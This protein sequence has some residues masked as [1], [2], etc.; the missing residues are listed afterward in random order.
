MAL[1]VLLADESSTIKKVMQLSLQDFGV[2]VKS[3]PL[4]VDVL[5][6]AQSFKPDLIFIDIL[7]QKKNGYEVCTDLKKDPMLSKVPVI[8]MWSGFMDLDEEKVKTAKADGRLEKP[9]DNQTL[10]SLVEKFVIKTQEH[11]LKGFLKFPD[12]PEFVEAK[13]TTPPTTPLPNLKPAARPVIPT[14]KPLEDFPPL[15]DAEF[16]QFKQV[17]LGKKGAEKS[18]SLDSFKLNLNDLNLEAPQNTSAPWQSSPMG[19]ERI[20]DSDFMVI[21]PG[22]NLEDLAKEAPPK[23]SPKINKPAS[24]APVTENEPAMN[25]VVN[26]AVAQISHEMLERAV[27]SQARDVLEVIA[28]KLLPDLVEKVVREELNKLLREL[29]GD[30]TK[31]P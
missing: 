26:R 19:E 17:P 5:A 24:R 10:R 7:L 9:F 3:V 4:G 30:V 18:G 8:L 16:D 23:P 25:D 11:P 13:P 1:R 28:W 31:S 20:Q 6:V 15:E 2:E 14:A 27:Q 21:P 22:G 12:L 29:E